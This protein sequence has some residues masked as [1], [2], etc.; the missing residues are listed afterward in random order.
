MCNISKYN[1]KV[2]Y[3]IFFLFLEKTKFSIVLMSAMA[4]KCRECRRHFF[5]FRAPSI[6]NCFYVRYQRR[7]GLASLM[8]LTFPL[9]VTHQVECHCR[10]KISLFDSADGRSCALCAA[11]RGKWKFVF[12]LFT[13][14]TLCE[15]IVLDSSHPF[16]G[17]CVARSAFN[18]P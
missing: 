11:Y 17:H 8:L 4:V 12:F 14:L 13:P 5:F 2:I 18:R 15:K 10:R 3:F 7:L 1:I 9:S 16:P 6:F